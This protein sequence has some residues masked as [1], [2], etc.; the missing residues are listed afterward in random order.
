MR[1]GSEK[2]REGKLDSRVFSHLGVDRIT[3]EIFFAISKQAA[4]VSA[5]PATAP[6]C[7]TDNFLRGKGFKDWIL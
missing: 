3:S 5:A 6:T 4:D 2:E 7:L 1:F